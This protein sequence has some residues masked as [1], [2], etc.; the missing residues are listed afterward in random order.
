M[1]L[2]CFVVDLCS[3]DIY[4]LHLQGQARPGA[5]PNPEVILDLA[6]GLV[7]VGWAQGYGLCLGVGPGYVSSSP[8]AFLII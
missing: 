5:S 6:L 4:K 3:I 7:F 8:R 2:R 1:L